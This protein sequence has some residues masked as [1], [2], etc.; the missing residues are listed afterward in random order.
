MGPVPQP[1]MV[2]RVGFCNTTCLQSNQKEFLYVTDPV[3][4]A[5]NPPDSFSTNGLVELLALDNSGTC[6]VWSGSLTR[7]HD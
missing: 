7:Q 4:S 6:S 2:V 3:A 5:P 1:A